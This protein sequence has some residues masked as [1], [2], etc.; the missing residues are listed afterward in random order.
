M[1][2]TRK[3]FIAFGLGGILT[4]LST[5][6]DAQLVEKPRDWSP[7]K[8]HEIMNRP[9][10]YRQVYDITQLGDGVFLNNIKNSLNGLQFSFGIQP[11]QIN[12]VAALHGAA[13]L[14]NFTDA[15]WKKYRLGE[16]TGLKDPKTGEFATRNLYYA[17]GADQADHNPDSEK[18]IYQDKSIQGLQARGVSFL[19]CHTATEEQSRKLIAH[20]GL[21]E[22]PETV[23]RD[24]LAHRIP[25][26]IVVPAMVATVAILQLDAHFSYITVAA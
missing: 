21:K 9:A 7:A 19:C 23:V 20:L 18:S 1:K 12:I 26:S 8:L 14:L 22:Q 15:M 11:S 17:S 2:I 3:D 4:T 5:Q 24:L 16:F 10:R 25:G 6:A 13:N